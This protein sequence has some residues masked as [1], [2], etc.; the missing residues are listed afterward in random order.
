[1]PALNDYPHSGPRR[2]TAPNDPTANQPP[3]VR[4][5]KKVRRVM[6]RLPQS[7][8]FP[9]L[10]AFP[11]LALSPAPLRAEEEPLR[12]LIDAEVRAAWQ[13]KKIVPADRAGDAAFLRRIY[14]DLLGTIPTLDETRQ[15]L[16]NSEPD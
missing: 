1:M 6:D 4:D 11:G 16:Q 15:F 5:S 12:Q 7:R 8:W 3:S 9:L 2:E 10:V 14:L 13:Q